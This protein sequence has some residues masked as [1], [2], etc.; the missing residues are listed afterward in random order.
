MPKWV[1]TG[2]VFDISEFDV[3]DMDLF[4]GVSVAGIDVERRTV[5]VCDRFRRGS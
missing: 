5:A 4:G 1:Y 2:R 3:L